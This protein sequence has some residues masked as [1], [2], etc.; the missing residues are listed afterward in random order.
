MERHVHG[1][2]D[3]NKHFAVPHLRSFQF[4][5]RF[6]DGRTNGAPGADPPALQWSVRESRACYGLVVRVEV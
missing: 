6:V 2:C 4:P 3:A 5:Q 1:A